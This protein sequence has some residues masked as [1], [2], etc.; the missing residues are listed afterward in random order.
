MNPS[1]TAVISE[2]EI[3][4]EYRGS[5]RERTVILEVNEQRLVVFENGNVIDEE[6]IGSEVELAL[7][8]GLS[9]D[10]TV[11]EDDEDAL[12]ELGIRQDEERDSRWAGTICADVVD[13]DITDRW[14]DN[15]Y[16]R[17]LKLDLGI[18][19]VVAT[20]NNEV[21]QRLTSKSVGCGDRFQTHA[22]RLGI[23]ERVD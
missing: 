16:A 10:V 20:A 2:M 12:C 5:V 21:D 4:S 22:W 6:D 3:E 19:T 17:V 13:D 23:V 14:F 7:H 18:G 11:A 8:V 9:G 1:L 15:A